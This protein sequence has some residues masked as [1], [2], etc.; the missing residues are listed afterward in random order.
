MSASQTDG[1]TVIPIAIGLKRHSESAI[2]RHV[3]DGGGT[4]I[5]E[6]SYP[7][8]LTTSQ[9][10]SL[11]FGCLSSNDGVHSGP[12]DGR[13]FSRNLCERLTQIFLMVQSDGRDGNRLRRGC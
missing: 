12:N 13:F 1:H 10:Y 8:F 3:Q 11:C 7:A 6:R 5:K 2:L 4:I 9:N